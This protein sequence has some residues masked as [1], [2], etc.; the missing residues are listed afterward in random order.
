MYN[1]FKL[2]AKLTGAQDFHLLLERWMVPTK[3]FQDPYMTK[4]RT[5][6]EKGK[7]KKMLF[8][9]FMFFGILY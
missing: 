9:R 6:T 8:F 3:P 1:N 4:S 5:T 2:I 7:L